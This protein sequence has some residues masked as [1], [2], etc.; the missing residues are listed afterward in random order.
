MQHNYTIA[1]RFSN[2]KFAVPVAVC[3]IVLFAS[4]TSVS[5]TCSLTDSAGMSR[6]KVLSCG[7]VGDYYPPYPYPQVFCQPD[8]TAF[9][10]RLRGKEIGGG[11]ETADGYTA[12]RDC[13]GWWKYVACDG[14]ISG[15]RI[16]LQA[17][18][19]DFK[20]HAAF[21]STVLDRKSVV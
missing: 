4:L 18:Q 3:A 1:H 7:Q 6:L 20:K 16:G 14:K 5:L 12:A 21:A 9:E 11:I 17:P 13:G 8:G 19:S 10:G 15:C 2:C